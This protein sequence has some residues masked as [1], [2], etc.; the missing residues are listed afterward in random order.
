MV[1]KGETVDAFI[2]GAGPVGLFFAYQMI[3][4]G[5]SVYICDPK[6]GPTDQ[7]RAV[8]LTP[9]TMEMM[10]NRKI[11]HHFLK[12]AIAVQGMQVHVHGS[13]VG[14][15][16][17]TA[18]DTSFPQMTCL[19]QEKTEAVLIKLVGE[20]RISWRTRL[21]DYTQHE[22]DI[23][24]IVKHTETDQESKI[25]ARYIIGAD[26]SHS[27]VRKQNSDWEY[28][29]FAIATKFGMADVT[30]SG[31][32][33]DKMM[34]N[35]SNGFIHADGMCGVVPI[36]KGANGQYYFRVVANLGPYEIDENK[37]KTTHGIHQEEPFTLEELQAIMEK[38]LHPL[39]IVA[40][41]PVWIT[42]FR[43]NERKASGF[44]RDRAFLIGD[45]A[46]CHSP[47]GG[48]GLNLGLQDGAVKGLPRIASN[49]IAKVVQC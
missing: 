13:K 22:N 27:V 46:H 14:T 25:Y 7:S 11:A 17:V 28:E 21:V 48:Q 45:A 35:R 30:L 36:G 10:E 43:I 23:E 20:E 34:N 29:G 37:G 44:R 38:R 31:K 12:E 1:S 8:L 24:A 2:S 42:Q 26:G 39:E 47:V 9:R 15:I 40:K 19:A 6:Q 49:K 33:A 41:N 18:G 32:D 4:L 5:H 16:D 3:Q